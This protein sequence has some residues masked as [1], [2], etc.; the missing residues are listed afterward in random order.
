MAQATKGEQAKAVALY[1]LSKGFLAYYFVLLPLLYERGLITTRQVGYIGAGFIMALIAAA[2][3]VA[4]R[5]H[6]LSTK[7][8][9]KRSS[10][11][12]LATSIVLVWTARSGNVPLLA[13]CYA[14]TG[15]SVG[16]SI[17]AVNALLASYTTK[18][19]RYGLL[20]NLS[21]ISS[22]S[23]IVYPILV[24]V[25]LLA[26]DNYYLTFIIGVLQAL[27]ILLLSS[28][29]S[30][31]SNLHL[32]SSDNEVKVKLL[33]KP[34]FRYVLS[35]EFLDSF[36]SAQLF[37]FLPI[38]FLS[39][40][41]SI[42][43]GFALQASVFFGYVVGTF[44]LSKLSKKYSGYR[45]LMIA[46]LGM[47]ITILA[48]LYLRGLGL[49]LFVTFLLGGFARGTSPILKAM[50]FDN[51]E[52]REYKKGG[53]MHVIAGDSGNAVAQLLFGL[54]IGWFGVKSPFFASAVVCIFI[55]VLLINQ[56]RRGAIH[57]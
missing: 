34:G 24:A 9:L 11:L 40:G 36:A 5:L 20:A 30:V 21:M 44:I 31:S 8:L 38:L 2:F 56:R 49:L 1:T 46:E 6:S 32:E 28:K 57:V 53:A 17:S 48:L 10:W 39:K 15:L 50:S 19:N 23:R 27:A 41:Y 51:L 29:V 14:L 43:N 42:L 13:A 33:T 7:S 26:S 45:S 55:I 12:V 18:G 3:L 25:V 16:L 4:N 35:L 22:L 54:L 37:V 52:E 47:V